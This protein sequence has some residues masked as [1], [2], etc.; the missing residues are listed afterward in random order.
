MNKNNNQSGS[1]HLIAIIILTVAL[2][3]TLGFVYWQNFGQV[4]EVEK[5]YVETNAN[6]VSNDNFYTISEWGVKGVWN[7]DYAVKPI[8]L[9]NGLLSLT[10]DN[11]TGSCIGFEVGRIARLAGNEIVGGTNSTTTASQE[12]V[13][14]KIAEFSGNKKIGEYYYVYSSPQQGCYQADANGSFSQSADPLTIQSS[15]KVH[16]FFA[17]LKEI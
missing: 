14:D 12:Y 2:I 4:E 1:T 13:V 11:L 6:E 10:T 16:D 17:S 5:T 9:T 15:E 8:S 3:G 7:E